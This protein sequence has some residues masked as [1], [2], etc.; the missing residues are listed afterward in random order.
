MLWTSAEYGGNAAMETLQYTT[1]IINCGPG[2]LFTRLYLVY[3]SLNELNKTDPRSKLLI[4][5]WFQRPTFSVHLT[6]SNTVIIYV[7]LLS[8]TLI[9]FFIIIHQHHQNQ[10]R[11]AI[12][13]LLFMALATLPHRSL[14]LPFSFANCKSS[15]SSSSGSCHYLSKGRLISQ[16]ESS[17]LCPIELYFWK[18]KK[19]VLI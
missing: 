2:R 10:L 6:T 8:C 3:H 19:W 13:S 1:T 15:F 9:S 5:W 7:S 14:S 11:F 16:L 12:S 4:W 17:N 18:E